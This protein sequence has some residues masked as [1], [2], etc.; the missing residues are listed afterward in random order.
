MRNNLAT[1]VT[2]YKDGREIKT[3]EKELYANIKSVTRSEF[4]ASMSA[5]QSPRYIFEFDPDDFRSC[6]VVIEGLDKKK[7]YHPAKILFDDE[8]YII[9]RVFEV[10]HSSVEVTVR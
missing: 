8:E 2:E 6:D 5:G 9:T 10:N 3:S 7:K 4:Y 1:V